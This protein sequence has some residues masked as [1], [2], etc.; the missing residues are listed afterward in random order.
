M[1]MDAP[2][3]LEDYLALRYRIILM[4]EEDGWGAI[5]P[6][7]PGCVAGADTPHEALTLLEDAKRGWLMSA[8][9]HG[10]PIPL[11]MNYDLETAV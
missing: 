9:E 3:T 4:P 6:E 8:L 2:Q 5:I 10:D 11:P 7:L 1:V